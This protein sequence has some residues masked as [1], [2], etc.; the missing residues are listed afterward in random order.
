MYLS[1]SQR[2]VNLNQAFRQ[3]SYPAI[4]VNDL[5]TNSEE[6]RNQLN[7][8]IYT[9]YSSDL[10][11][12]VPSCECGKTAGQYNVGVKCSHCA[13]EC[14]SSIETTLK[15][16]L[17]FRAPD[18]VSSLINPTIWAMLTKRLRKK[19]FDVLRW[20]CDSD[21][22]AQIKAPPE[23]AMIRALGIP[24]SLNHFVDNFDQVL[25]TL[26]SFDSYRYNGPVD[27]LQCLINENKDAVFTNYVPLPN[28]SLLIIENTNV[29]R[30]ADKTII[31]LIDAVK[32]MCSVD[33]PDCLYG[34]HVKE[35]RAAR[36]MALNA[37]FHPEYAKQNIGRKPGLARQH[38]FGSSSHFSFRAVVTSLTEK[39]EHD[40]I[41]IPWGVA[42]TVLRYHILNKL[43]RYGF[44]SIQ[45]SSFINYYSAIYHPL[46]D[47]IFNELIEE[48]ASGGIPCSINRNPSLHRGSF[49]SVRITKVKTDPNQA[50]VS[51]SILIT[52]PLNADKSSI[53][54]MFLKKHN[55]LRCRKV[56]LVSNN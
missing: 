5:S 8:Q 13:T 19:Q 36:A 3:L 2:L 15:P 26:F 48:T 31:G 46:L 43:H 1:I 25:S 6:K 24:R 44:N 29:G 55:Y 51:F 33:T 7:N 17:W 16:V 37:E 45:A 40:E 49:Q 34:T 52:P 56:L 12:S 38:I 39:H 14:A 54:C 11:E 22:K 50:S 20:M 47:K 21:Y 23:V 42:C 28:R 18:G 10:L 9:Q 35:N 41:H 4:I 53:K 32:L 27:Y 30:F